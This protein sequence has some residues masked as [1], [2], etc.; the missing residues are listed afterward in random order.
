MLSLTWTFVGRRASFLTSYQLLSVSRL[1]LFDIKELGIRRC[2]VL[3]NIPTVYFYVAC[4]CVTLDCH[5]GTHM[6]RSRKRESIICNQ[7]VHAKRRNYALTF[8]TMHNQHRAL[9]RNLKDDDCQVSSKWKPIDWMTSSVAFGMPAN[10]TCVPNNSCLH[11]KY[12]VTNDRSVIARA[13]LEYHNKTC[14]RF[15]PR[16][17]QRDYIHIMPGSG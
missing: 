11:C 16:T 7:H 2:R 1:S 12:K 10:H 5:S 6:K 8:A 15:V 17:N 9:R 3:W 13:M 4:W 14:I